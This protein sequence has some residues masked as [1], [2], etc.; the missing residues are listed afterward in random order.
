MRIRSFLLPLAPALVLAFAGSLAPTAHAALGDDLAP[1]LKDDFFEWFGFSETARAPGANGETVITFGQRAG[2]Q[3][4]SVVRLSFGV[5]A[6]GV[7][8]SGE[9]SLARSF[10]EGP[11]APFAVDVTKSFLGFTL[12]GADAK[13]AG[14]IANGELPKMTNSRRALSKATVDFTT[15]PCDGAPWTTIRIAPSDAS[16]R[17]SFLTASDLPAG[18]RLS[19]DSRDVGPDADDDAFAANHG[20][21]SG[22]VVW[23][24][25]KMDGAMWRVVDIR[26]T[27]PTD[28]DA[29]AYLAAS[30][31]RISE[32]QPAVASPAMTAIGAGAR[33]FGGTF[34]EPLLGTKMTQFMLGFRVGRTVVKLYAAQGSDA[35]PGTLK[36]EA[37][38]ALG[39]KAAARA[40]K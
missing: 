23:M 40:P 26:W 3:F 24:S 38:A 5:D 18:L 9:L 28:A 21:R 10:I 1:H 36:V 11:T 15:A 32:N 25:D 6:R 8:T 37:L 33:A 7:L 22:L 34:V 4:G 12:P 16:W 2:S 35:K 14:D 31:R 30:W 29:E 19:Q 20:Q 27:F 39:H 17:A 13:S